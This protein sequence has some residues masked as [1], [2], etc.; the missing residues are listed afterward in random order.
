MRLIWFKI[1]NE[2]K[3]VNMQFFTSF[4]HNNVVCWVSYQRASPPSCMRNM[5]RNAPY[6]HQQA[7]RA[8]ERILHGSI[9][10]FRII[11]RNFT[12]VHRASGKA[13]A[14]SHNYLRTKLDKRPFK[15]TFPLNSLFPKCQCPSLERVR[16]QFVAFIYISDLIIRHFDSYWRVVTIAL[17]KQEILTENRHFNEKMLLF[18][19]KYNHVRDLSIFKVILTQQKLISNSLFTR[20]FN[21]A[22]PI[23]L[24]FIPIALV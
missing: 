13:V 11:E 24:I 10:F 4:N 8:R 1:M 3:L 17:A 7:S 6:S 22:F 15:S 2:K 23:L 20:H 16:A 21:S 18:C 5:A 19:R 9:T 12:S 14:M